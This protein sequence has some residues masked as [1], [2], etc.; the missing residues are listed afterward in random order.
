MARV[1]VCVPIWHGRWHLLCRASAVS[2]DGTP[3]VLQLV[4]AVVFKTVSTHTTRTDTQEVC[5]LHV[6]HCPNLHRQ[7]AV[8]CLSCLRARGGRHTWHSTKTTRTTTCWL[9]P[10]A[11]VADP[12]Q[13]RRTRP[14][15]CLRLEREREQKKPV[16]CRVH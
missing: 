10:A 3:R 8:A 9:L 4:Q 14:R 12:G 6:L 15:W 1:H 7:S 11:S 13:L 5:G 2:L 16:L